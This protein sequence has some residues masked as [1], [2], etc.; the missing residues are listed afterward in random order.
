MHRE[1]MGHASIQATM[2]TYGRGQKSEAK[3]QANSKV[4]KFALR[5]LI[6]D[7]EPKASR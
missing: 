2:D 3:R 5:P 1:L 4:V 6:A 7:R